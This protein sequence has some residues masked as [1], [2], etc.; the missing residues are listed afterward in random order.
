MKTYGLDLSEHNGSL[1]FD[2]IAKT[3]DFVILRAGY[4]TVRKDNKFAE[5]YK[6]AK[7]KGLKV[8]AYWYSYSLNTEQAL[9]EAKMFLDVIKGKKFEMPVFIDMEDA[10][11][12][13]RNNGFPSNK[14]LCDIC[15]VFCQRMELSGY[16]VG[17]YASESWL[18]GY[19]ASLVKKN[20]YTLWCANWGSN[21]GTLQAD[22][23]KDYNLHQ[24]TSEYRLGGK[25]FDRNVMYYDY[26]KLIQEMGFN[27]FTKNDKPATVK[28]STPKKE[29]KK[30]AKVK[31]TSRT[32]Y[33]GVVNDSWVL[34]STFTILENPKGERVVIGKN[35]QVT[36]A[37]K[38]SSLKLV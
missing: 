36:G 10:D 30:G 15:D 17:I 7:S 19:L 16:F 8:G 37:W 35:G 3:H 28:P 32:D 4:G 23:S 13:K 20:R 34:N 29:F 31:V 38:K 24:F 14:M 33:N 22:R 12:Y 21:D 18:T 2:T 27:G 9:E 11:S 26:P 6:L 5:Y 25:R 1:D